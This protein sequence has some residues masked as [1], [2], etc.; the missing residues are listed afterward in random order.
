MN[1]SEVRI[2]ELKPMKIASFH[3]FSTEPEGIALNAMYEWAE[4]HGYFKTENPRCFGFNNPDPTPGSSNYGYEV[5]LV[6]P[7]GMSVE[8]IPVKEFGG[9]LYAV[10]NCNG[11]IE[12]AGVFIP[13]AWKELVEWVE[14]SRY[15]MG[16]H[17]WLEEQVPLQGL[18]LPEMN[19][20]GKLNLD[21]YLPLRN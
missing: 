5:W 14:N 15:K 3:G 12:Q 19:A 18:S 10:S 1:S 16:K 2:T 11:N 8:D 13:S 6:I 9:G 17:Q 21:L 20:Q 7:E 4:K